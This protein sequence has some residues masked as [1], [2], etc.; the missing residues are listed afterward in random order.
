MST[1]NT[2]VEIIIAIFVIYY[3]I[4][5]YNTLSCYRE[6]VRKAWADIDTYREQKQNTLQRLYEVANQ[7]S[8]QEQNIHMQASL[9]HMPCNS[10][11]FQALGNAYPE[12]KTNQTY[13]SLMRSIESLEGN[14]QHSRQ[15]YN[16]TVSRYQMLRSQIPY[17]FL[18]PL[19]GFKTAQ[20]N[21]CEE[22]IKIVNAM[23]S[24][25]S[26]RNQKGEAIN[27]IVQKKSYHCPKCYAE[28][29]P[30]TGKYGPYWHCENTACQNNFPDKDGKPIIISCPDCHKGY[31]RK[32]TL[33]NKEYWTCS[34]YPSC[35]AK[36]P[37]DAPAILALM[38]KA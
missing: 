16:D 3:L 17:C 37:V 20:Y 14:I 35:K 34:G 18:A 13:L 7:F 30:K 1:V 29:H 2:I 21:R 15:N 12:L 23:P 25:F 19:F 28:L 11:N 5:K 31:L 27:E 32:R 8:Q 6:P 36:Y 24:S 26:Q 10:A 33:G 22:E 38:P 9:A 4:K